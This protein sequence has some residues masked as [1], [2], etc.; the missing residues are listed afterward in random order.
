MD[1]F[2]ALSN[3]PANT[4]YRTPTPYFATQFL[5]SAEDLSGYPDFFKFVTQHPK[6]ETR[7]LRYIKNLCGADPIISD[8][9]DI[10]PHYDEQTLNWEATG[11]DRDELISAVYVVGFN[12]DKKSARD[13]YKLGAVDIALKE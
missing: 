11:L 9:G 6:E 12:P 2:N 3:V 10:L 7:L 5:T 13:R 4:V 1:Q 8:I